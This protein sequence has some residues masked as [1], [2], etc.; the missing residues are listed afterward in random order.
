MRMQY[1]I[2]VNIINIPSSLLSRYRYGT[3]HSK[4]DLVNRSQEKV[5]I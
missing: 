2:N 5:G 3:A 1:S 4:V